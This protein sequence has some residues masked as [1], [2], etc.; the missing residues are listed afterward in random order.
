MRDSFFTL[1]RVLSGIQ[2]TGELHIGNYLGAISQWLDLQR[3]HECIFPIVDLHAITIPYD[4]GELRKNILETTKAYLACGIDPEKCIIFV[5]SQIREHTE[6]CWYL[7][8][9]IPVSELVRMTQYKEKS[10]QFKK[11]IN[12]GLLN[13]PILQAADILLYQTNLVPV[14]KDQEQHV[15]LARV[16]A[17]K[18][19]NR[20]GKTFQEPKV[21]VPK[22]GARIMALTDPRKKMSKSL[23]PKAY[24]SLFDEPGA[25]KQKVMQAVT[26]PGK[27]VKYNPAKKPG[28]SNLL[29]I[30]S[31]FSQEPIPRLEKK[32][33]KSGYAPFKK[34]LAQFLIKALEPFRRKKRE[35]G[36]R[37]V[38]IHEILTQSTK[39]AQALASSTMAD[40]REKMGLV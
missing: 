37:D 7:N 5:Q 32:F 26:D 27:E 14:G 10:R 40:V 3:E 24:L 13:Y 17:R 21:L 9:I 19:N 12:A 33:R 22:I 20:F 38:Y 34:S 39:R 18:F 23:G 6:L 29:T 36:S 2:P 11:D 35:M 25:I 30:Y 8:T 4:P 28:I 16:I 1:M 31:L 15:E